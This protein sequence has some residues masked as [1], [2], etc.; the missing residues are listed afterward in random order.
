MK[1]KGSVSYDSGP[2]VVGVTSTVRKQKESKDNEAVLT[3]KPTLL[4]RPAAKLPIV[5]Q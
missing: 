1:D 2:E 4:K 5:R 3:K